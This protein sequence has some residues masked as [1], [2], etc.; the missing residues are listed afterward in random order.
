MRCDAAPC[1]GPSSGTAQAPAAAR[2]AFLL[3]CSK[4]VT[5][6]AARSRPRSVVRKLTLA[7]ARST[8]CRGDQRYKHIE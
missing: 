1:P 8:L 7:V 4:T 2:R 6:G 3:R 5:P